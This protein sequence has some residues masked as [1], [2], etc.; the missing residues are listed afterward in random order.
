LFA[1]NLL[2]T[3]GKLFSETIHPKTDKRHLWYQ[4]QAKNPH[5]ERNNILNK[6]DCCQPTTDNDNDPESLDYN[7]DALENRQ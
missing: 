5:K 1:L 3:L 6:T 4:L 2:A 7:G